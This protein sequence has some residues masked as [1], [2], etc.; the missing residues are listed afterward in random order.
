MRSLKQ[1]KLSKNFLLSEFTYSDTALDHK[2]DNNVYDDGVLENIKSLVCVVLQPLREAVERSVAIT[3]G[4]RS[5]F[6]NKTLNA[7]Q[8]SQHSKG[9]AADIQV[10]GMTNL[11]VCHWILDNVPFDQLIA[12]YRWSKNRKVWVEWTHVSHL[13]DAPNR[14]ETL[15][16]VI[17][18]EGVKHVLYG[19]H[20]NEHA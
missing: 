11:E 9:E 1:V 14:F 19:L 17:D 15:T 5:W 4:F 8:S 7:A 12:E 13:A 2:I 10:A 20:G 6:L 3:S 16:I 18:K